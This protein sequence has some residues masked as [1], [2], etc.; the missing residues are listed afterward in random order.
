MLNKNVG[1]LCTQKMFY[2]S[3]LLLAQNDP[4]LHF[5]VISYLGNSNFVI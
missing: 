2:G 1:T 5:D 3:F 4:F